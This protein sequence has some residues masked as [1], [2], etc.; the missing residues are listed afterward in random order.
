MV[1][2]RTRQE[3]NPNDFF[4]QAKKEYDTFLG[5]IEH[6]ISAETKKIIIVPDGQLAYTDGA[7]QNAAQ[8]NDSFPYLTTPVAGSNN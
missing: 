3:S 1:S 2:D 5:K 4:A 7:L 6:L 8:F